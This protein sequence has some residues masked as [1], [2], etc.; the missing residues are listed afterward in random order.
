MRESGTGAD[1]LEF[2]DSGLTSDIL[3]MPVVGFRVLAAV[4]AFA[5]ALIVTYVYRVHAR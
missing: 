2:R 5:I 3:L 1:R 4:S